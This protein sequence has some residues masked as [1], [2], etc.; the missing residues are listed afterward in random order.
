MSETQHI[1]DAL[2]QTRA[3]LLKIKA[4][5]YRHEEEPKD[6]PSPTPKAS[7]D[8]GSDGDFDEPEI[9][10]VSESSPDEDWEKEKVEFFRKRRKPRGTGPEQVIGMRGGK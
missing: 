2:M 1:R 5:K 3:H 9:P 6:E 10:S 4:G 7:P 8:R